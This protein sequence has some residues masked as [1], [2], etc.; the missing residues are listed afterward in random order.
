MKEGNLPLSHL[1]NEK[2]NK[3]Q[4]LDQILTFDPIE[5]REDILFCNLIMT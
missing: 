2:I 1:N 4:T 3:N 5:G